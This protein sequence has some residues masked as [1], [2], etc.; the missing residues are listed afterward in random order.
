MIDEIGMLIIDW[1]VRTPGSPGSNPKLPHCEKE[2]GLTH[3][4]FFET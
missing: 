1:G 2:L 3:V 4:G